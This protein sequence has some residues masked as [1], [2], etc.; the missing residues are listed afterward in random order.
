MKTAKEFYQQQKGY[1]DEAME[2][3]SSTVFKIMDE[4]WN[5][6]IKAACENAIIGEMF[7]EGSYPIGANVQ[8]NDTDIL[9]VHKESILKLLKK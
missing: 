3:V 5:E 1:C 9:C 7:E 8:V 4:Y 2:G 6:A